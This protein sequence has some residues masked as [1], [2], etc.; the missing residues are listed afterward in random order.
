M[1]SAKT[2]PTN[3]Y[4]GSKLASDRLISYAAA[5]GLAAV[6]LRY[7]NVGGVSGRFGNADSTSTRIIPVALHAAA[8]RRHA[9]RVFGTNYP[10]A[11]ES[12]LGRIPGCMRHCCDAIAARKQGW[13]GQC[14]DPL[15]S[16]QR[17]FNVERP[18]ERGEDCLSSEAALYSRL[19]KIGKLS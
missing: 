7:F 1:E 4:G 16:V 10:T 5:Y 18:R 12:D 2:L 9:V 11:D 17:S 19:R 3:P 8:R 14:V 6:S 15:L 13:F